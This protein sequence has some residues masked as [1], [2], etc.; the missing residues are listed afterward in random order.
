MIQLIYVSTA[1]NLPAES[2]LLY[3][4]EQARSRNLRRHITGMLLYSNG[5]FL[6]LLEGEAKEVREL[7]EAI[8]R[9]PRN[10]GHVILRESQIA[11]RDFPDWSMGF[12]NL[13]S[14]VPD[15]IPGFVEVFGG[16]LDR[17]IAVNNITNAVRLL[18]NFAKD[19]TGR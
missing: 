4:L 8:C 5:T 13:E 15:E 14:R 2:E 18:L 19:R 6:Q 12:E 9:D 7:Y 1:T 16:R 17:S 10:E 11:G 3:L